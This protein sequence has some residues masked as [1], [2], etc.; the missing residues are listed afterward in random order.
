MII[1]IERAT[2]INHFL[3]ASLFRAWLRSPQLSRETGIFQFFHFIIR[4]RVNFDPIRQVMSTH[5]DNSASCEQTLTEFVTRLTA[6][7]FVA[8]LNENRNRFAGSRVHF[9]TGDS[10]VTFFTAG[11]DQVLNCIILTF[12]NLLWINQSNPINQSINQSISQSVSQSVGQSINN[13]NF[14]IR[15]IHFLCYNNLKSS[16]VV[17]RTRTAVFCQV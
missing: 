8:Q 9:L 13:L 12:V 7:A 16:Q 2:K 1:I 4:N 17:F 6:K 14:P 15:Q 3:S 5:R 11:S 10:S